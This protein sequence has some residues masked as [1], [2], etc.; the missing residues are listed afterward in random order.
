MQF[1]SVYGAE[2]TEYTKTLILKVRKQTCKQSLESPGTIVVKVPMRHGGGTPPYQEH[3]C[4]LI[5]IL[6]SH[7]YTHLKMNTSNFTARYSAVCL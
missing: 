6:L 7:T 5:Y 2:D 4:L 3:A 1:Y